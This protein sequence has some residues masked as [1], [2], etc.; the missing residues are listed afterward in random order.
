MTTNRVIWETKS[1][2]LHEL[3]RRLHTEGFPA[4]PSGHSFRKK[5]TFGNVAVHLNIAEYELEF[6]AAVDVSVRLDAVEELVNRCG[7]PPQPTAA[8]SRKTATFGCELGTLR[9]GRRREWRVVVGR[10]DVAKIASEMAQLVFE[11]GLPY[12]GRYSSLE[13]VYAVFSSDD[14]DAGIHVAPPLWRGERA[15]ALGFILGG[16]GEARRMIEMKRNYLQGQDP[17]HAQL[18]ERFVACFKKQ[19]GIE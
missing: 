3:G 11:M 14:V 9:E 2:L 4:R 17:R 15:V 18:F 8:E 5:T 6:H 16:V 13:A 19:V 1:E 12:F 10:T 7:P